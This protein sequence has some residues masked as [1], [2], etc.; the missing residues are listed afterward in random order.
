MLIV[1]K[2]ATRREIAGRR[3][4]RQQ[5][6]SRKSGK[7]ASVHSVLFALIVTFILSGLIITLAD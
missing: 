5:F 7:I 4:A 2:I 1:V 6:D 3:T